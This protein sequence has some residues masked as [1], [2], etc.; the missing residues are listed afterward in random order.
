[1]FLHRYTDADATVSEHDIDMNIIK[2]CTSCA[3]QIFLPR[4]SKNATLTQY[5]EFAQS[6]LLIEV[7]WHEHP[8][9]HNRL[10]HWHISL[11][12]RPLS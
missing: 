7:L 6:S 1:M 2:T 5:F 8:I 12:I 10:L 3:S 9:F 4:V 11:W